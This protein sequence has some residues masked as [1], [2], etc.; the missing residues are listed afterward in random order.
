M[1]R[2]YGARGL[3]G[4]VSFVSSFRNGSIMVDPKRPDDDGGRPSPDDEADMSARLKRLDARLGEIA[5]GRE[6]AAKA[7]SRKTSDMSGLGQALRLSAEFIA[8][9][10]AGG[11]LGWLF[12]WW[13]GT[14]PWGF[15]VGLLLGFCSGMFNM[16]R[17]SGEWKRDATSANPPGS[18]ERSGDDEKK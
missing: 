16:L 10:I 14:S 5:N 17:A 2:Q 13:L 12:D 15:I 1:P 18:A 8:G 9:I 4:W 3:R 6:D 7:A 11:F